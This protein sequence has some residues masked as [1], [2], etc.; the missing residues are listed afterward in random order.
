[1]SGEVT[2]ATWRFSVAANFVRYIVFGLLSS[3]LYGKCSQL[4]PRLLQ[5]HSRS[6]EY[7]ETYIKAFYLTEN[8]ME[9]WIREHKVSAKCFLTASI[10]LDL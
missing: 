5:A 9:R 2:S 10:D 4:F 8:E 1:M 3:I 6:R 7:V